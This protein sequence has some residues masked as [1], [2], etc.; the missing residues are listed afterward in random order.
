MPFFECDT[1]RKIFVYIVAFSLLLL[2]FLFFNN[3]YRKLKHY[4]ELLNTVSNVN[5]SFQNLYKEIHKAAVINPELLKIYNNDSKNEYL[6]FTDS[7]TVIKKLDVLKSTVR[8]SVNIKIAAQLDSLIKAQLSWILL[9]NV[10]DSIIH[11][12]ASTHISALQQI[13]LLISQGIDRTDFLLN[14]HKRELN[15][16]IN[17]VLLSLVIFIFLSGFFLFYLI[18]TLYWQQ[19]EKEK[20][21]KELQK[22]KIQLK[23]VAEKQTLLV[24]IVNS[25]EDA[26]IS[27][28]LDGTV[29]S[30]NHGAEMLF[31]YSE[32]EAKGMPIT[33]I[34]PDELLSEEAMI[35]S[36]IRN[37]KSVRHYETERIKKDGTHISVSLRISPIIDV[38]G[39]ITGASTIAR[40]ITKRKKAENELQDYMLALDES[41]IIAMTDNRGVIL[42]VNDNFC[43]I[44]GYSENELVGN[45]HQII[46]SDFHSKDFFKELWQTI[47]SGK[48]WRGEIKNK[49]KDGSYYWVYTTITPFLDR[50]NKPFQYLAIR[51][52]IT[53][54]KLAEEDVLNSLK[55]KNTILESIGDA[56]FAV[57][58]NWTVTYWNGVAETA[59][60][61]QRQDIIGKNLWLVFPD[62][63]DSK[64]YKEYNRAVE[65][66]QIIDFQDYY[67]LL[68]KWYEISAYPTDNGLSVYFKDITENKF[69]QIQLN[70]L[71]E[72]LQQ[73]TKAL[74]IS[75]T[76]LEQFAYVA[77]HDLQEPLR[78]VTSFLT[79]LEKKYGNV[80]DDK[81]K[82]YINFAVDGA[83]RM[84]QI[85]L[86]LLEFS[87]IGRIK[88]TP[89]AI[90]LNE[91]VADI[92]ILY[93]RK[94]EEKHAV[95][96]VDNLP[97]IT[98]Y[99]SPILQV[100]QNLIAN[101]LKYCKKEIP[102]HIHISVENTDECWRFAV[103]DNGIGIDSEYFDKIFIIFQRLH[104]K[105]EYSGTG[106]GLA[107]T[108][109]IVESIG[110]KIWVESVEGQGSTF[111]FTIPK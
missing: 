27:K 54:K 84:R 6:F 83:K 55:E 65:T 14:N 71:N 110:G 108:K 61:V 18:I 49:K 33:I 46:N 86:D 64:S 91:L 81:G 92:Q 67:K 70:E 8:D 15:D 7:I 58:K 57:D 23:E 60:S 89:E 63:L 97:I 98:G 42:S 90:D 72:N 31:G 56:F 5:T 85:I 21:K 36:K 26:I 38:D 50:N 107:I 77:S 9:S 20:N 111:Y 101:A 35:I 37:G 62:S 94:I 45:T 1:M 29:I 2:S 73:Q 87:R 22:S 66:R 4:K 88:D 53:E 106:M 11:H 95:I 43:D 47:S 103:A 19:V 104:N 105:D 12:K 69:A 24:S 75:N 13:N 78:M 34:I 25:S 99:K 68:N 28:T 41:S 44:S 39:N 96:H 102:A 82:S 79:Q 93:R 16:A 30:W 3:A 59:L 10:P 48:I 32:Y 100:F 74:T 76:E 52:D 109:K 17:K 80:L 40:D 51:F